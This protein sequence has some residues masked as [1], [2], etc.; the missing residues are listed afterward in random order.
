MVV[1]KFHLNGGMYRESQTS[2]D[3]IRLR[4]TEFDYDRLS[5]ITTD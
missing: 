1:L 2:R 3:A 5:S 4:P